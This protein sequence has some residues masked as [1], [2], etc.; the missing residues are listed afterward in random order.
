M[1]KRRRS[2]ASNGAKKFRSA[3]DKSKWK[4]FFALLTAGEFAGEFNIEREAGDQRILDI[5]GAVEMLG[6]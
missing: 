2:R 3:K 1:Q 6:K 4:K 5:R